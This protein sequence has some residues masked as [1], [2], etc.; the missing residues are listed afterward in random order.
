[1]PGTVLR[2]DTLSFATKTRAWRYD[3]LG[4]MGDEGS[5]H[6]MLA[7]AGGFHIYTAAPHFC[8]RSSVGVLALPQ[9]FVL[10]ACERGREK[11]TI[12]THVSA[13]AA[14]P[15]MIWNYPTTWVFDPREFTLK[16][17]PFEGDEETSTNTFEIAAEHMRRAICTTLSLRDTG[18]IPGYSAEEMEAM[19]GRSAQQLKDVDTSDEWLKCDIYASPYR[20]SGVDNVTGRHH[21]VDLTAEDHRANVPG[22]QED[23]TSYLKARDQVRWMAAIDAPP[24][25]ACGWEALKPYR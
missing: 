16:G 9:E 6:E 25:R 5:H 20:Y 24:C 4:N 19:T 12:T 17:S 2:L 18:I 13:P 15:P 22:F 8:S 14:V 11:A 10:P 3:L 7:R 1:M 21:D 23:L